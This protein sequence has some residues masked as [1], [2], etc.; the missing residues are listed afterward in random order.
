MD[1]GMVLDSRHILG[2][3]KRQGQT[4]KRTAHRG[5]WIGQEGVITVANGKGSAFNNLVGSKIFRS[6]Q[7]LALAHIVV[8]CLCQCSPVK[9]FAV[10]FRKLRQKVSNFRVC[11]MV[12]LLGAGAVNGIEFSAHRRMGHDGF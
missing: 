10:I 11:Y 6:Q 4:D 2:F 7:T 9:T 12:T 5:L 8:N 1:S 3:Q